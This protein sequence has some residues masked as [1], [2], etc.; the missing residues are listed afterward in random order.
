M[1][2]HTTIEYVAFYLP[3]I[4]NHGRNS[5]KLSG[6][7]GILDLSFRRYASASAS[8][9]AACK[10]L[11]AATRIWKIGNEFGI[12]KCILCRRAVGH[13][14][15]SKQSTTC[16]ISSR[17]RE[18]NTQSSYRHQ[19]LRV[20]EYKY[21]RQEDGIMVFLHDKHNANALH[22]IPSSHQSHGPGPHS[23]HLCRIPV[24]YFP[25]LVGESERRMVISKV[26]DLLL[27]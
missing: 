2:T 27:G 18:V 3:W 26:L 22:R 21:G 9:C 25:R 6:R 24:D 10:A 5:T 12:G 13:T 15:N 23:F 1:N 14:C 19:T 4:P 8:A 20:R 11:H 17:L 7:G 16:I